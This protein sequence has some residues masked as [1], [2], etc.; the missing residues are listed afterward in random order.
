MREEG[1]GTAGIRANGGR[2]GRELI[3]HLSC[4]IAYS[5]FGINIV[6]CKDLTGSHILSSISLFSLRAMGA[7]ALFWL[8]SIFTPREKVEKKDFP[9]IAL[10]SLLGFFAPQF[11][12]LTALP[13]I[14][15]MT[16]SILSSLTPIYTMFIAA[17]AI[18]EPI[19]P[20]K[21]AGVMLSFIGIVFLILDSSTGR[22]GAASNSLQ[23]IL[24]MVSNGIFFA[25]YLGIFRPLI[26]KYAVVTF[27]KWIFLFAAVMTLPFSAGELSHFDWTLLHGSLGWELAFLVICATF[28][29]YFLIPLGQ[30]YIR[31]T[32]VSMYNYCQP[33]IAT[34]ISIIIGMDTLSA[35]KILT[36]LAVLAGVVMVSTSKKK[37]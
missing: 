19:T 13:Q 10:A 27:M 25:L 12:F 32:L 28:I 16:S 33:I 17:I 7:G 15:P 31:P 1:A 23:G 36:A 18:K 6:T 24:L 29:S 22:S 37:A 21:F 2:G 30:K 14:T 5:I 11:T 35:Q 3:G 8:I 34:T 20:K 26:Q 4:F 9:K